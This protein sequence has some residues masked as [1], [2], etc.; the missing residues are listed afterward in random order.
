MDVVGERKVRISSKK[1]GPVECEI[2]FT[3]LTELETERAEGML[4][5]QWWMSGK[6][7]RVVFLPAREG[8]PTPTDDTMLPEWRMARPDAEAAVM[9]MELLDTEQKWD[10]QSASIIV[11]HL[12]G[13][14]YSVEGYIRNAEALEH[15]GFTCLRS[16]R[17][18]NGRFWEIWFLPG[19]WAATGPLR[20]AIR[21]L[22]KDEQMDAALKFIPKNVSFGTLDI[23]VQRMAL[24]ID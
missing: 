12:C 24:V 2:S 19:L 16:R 8:S 6:D 21:R 20:E 13:Y 18:D 9:Q 10:G 23:A 17:G 3:G 1:R 11:Q 15:C 5:G 4:H 14:N 22:P 7:G